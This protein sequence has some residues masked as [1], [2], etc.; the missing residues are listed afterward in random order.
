MIDR[1]DKAKPKQT[2]KLIVLTGI[3]LLII[4]YFPEVIDKTKALFAIFYPLLLGALIAFILNILMSGYEKLYFPASKNRIIVGTRRGMCVVLSILTIVLI[5]YFVLRIIIPQVGHTI[6]LISAG[7]PDM[8]NNVLTWLK[9]YS[10]EIPGLQQRLAALNMDGA[11]IMQK[12]LA[13]FGNWAFGT[14]SFIGSV[15]SKIVTFILALIFS[16]YILF[17]KENLKIRFNKLFMAYMSKERREKFYKDLRLTSRVFSD[18]I[19]GQCKEA[20]ILG[21]LCAIGMWIFGFPY[22]LS[23]GSVIGLTALI[24]IIGAYI[25]AAI[26]FFLIVIV[27]PVKAL[28]FI[29]FIVVLQQIEGNLIYPKVVGNSIGLPGIWVL[30]AITIGGGLMGIAGVLLGVPVAATI[31][32][33]LGQDVNA[34]LNRSGLSSDI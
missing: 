10:D 13:L 24:P 9:Q 8:Y 34:R 17:E 7:F 32:K 25:G 20:L 2:I 23:V 33:L 26:G 11:A 22:A 31:Y 27:D 1:L 21:G 14:A 18:Y 15:F 3:V 4:L 16:I 19:I 12:G 30:A 29:V 5:V 28:L 6:H